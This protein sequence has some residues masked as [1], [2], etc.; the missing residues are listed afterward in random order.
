VNPLAIFTAAAA[1]GAIAAVLAWFAG[2]WPRIA[3][4]GAVVAVACGFGLGA[5]LLRARPSWPPGDVV[6]RW[7]LV[8]VPS[9]A[10]VEVLAAAGTGRLWPWMFRGVI[11][12]LLAP[13]LLDG[14]V[15]VSD[16]AGAGSRQWSVARIAATYGV[17]AVCLIG[18]WFAVAAAAGRSSGRIV[19]LAV[20]L[21][22]AAAGIAVAISGYATGG[23]LGIPLAAA[24]IGAGMASFFLDDSGWLCNA[25]GFG[26]VGLFAQ[27]LVGHWF[28]SL[29]LLATGLLLA[30]PLA[31]GALRL[32][33]IDRRGGWVKGL[34]AITVTGIP[35]ACAM[36]A[37]LGTFAD[38]VNPAASGSGPT[39]NDYYNLGK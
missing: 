10:L 4:A 38:D 27:V 5:W 6:G 13:A 29:S 7:L 33:L 20:G 9:A 34:A 16:A 11:A 35:V 37:A 23:T 1:A 32:P 2:R 8:V 36:M 39:L 25:T 14:T 28:G 24:L 19:T 15:Y 26:V 12:A 18:T 31:L 30:S 17:V 22:V 3:S 21:I